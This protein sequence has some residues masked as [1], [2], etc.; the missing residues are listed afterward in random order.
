MTNEQQSRFAL[1][2]I[3]V[4]VGGNVILYLMTAFCALSWNPTEWSTHTR[5]I[6][7]VLAVVWGI[8]VVQG[9]AEETEEEPH[10]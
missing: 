1:L 2:A 10:D 7:C 4:M 5:V 8:L 3:G 6:L 9:Y